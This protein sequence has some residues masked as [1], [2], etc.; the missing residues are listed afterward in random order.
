MAR[1]QDIGPLILQ[2]LLLATLNHPAAFPMAAELPALPLERQLE[3]R[4]DRTAGSR[5]FTVE[6]PFRGSWWIELRSTRPATHPS[7]MVLDATGSRPRTLERVESV[8]LEV[9]RPGNHLVCL[10]SGAPLGEVELASTFLKGGDP[11]EIEVDPEPLASPGCGSFL[12][13]G[14][15]MEIEVDPE[16]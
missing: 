16:P 7:L 11:M 3:W 2:L 9:C 13:G 6:V 12:K 15:P 4:E 14:D 8:M 10:T 1:Y 5:C